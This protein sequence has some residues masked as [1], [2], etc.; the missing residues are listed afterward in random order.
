MSLVGEEIEAGGDYLTLSELFVRTWESILSN[1][2]NVG[3]MISFVVFIVGVGIALFAVKEG[4]SIGDPYPGYTAAQDRFEANRSGFID[5]RNRHLDDLQDLRDDVI[6]EIDSFIKAADAGK[7]KAINWAQQSRT[8]L[9]SYRTFRTSTDTAASVIA[10]RYVSNLKGREKS[11]VRKLI[12]ERVKQAL[13]HDTDIEALVADVC[14][15]A[16][17]GAADASDARRQADELRTET[18]EAIDRQISEFKE[19]FDR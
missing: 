9:Q 17:A 14:K 19:K 18:I 15:A 1:P 8:L 3:D 12:A 16:E 2:A 7:T 6:N 13:A 5:R 11:S 10:D 4:Y